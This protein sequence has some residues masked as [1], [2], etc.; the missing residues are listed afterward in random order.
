MGDA[1]E[2]I[3]YAAADAIDAAL[4]REQRLLE[5]LRQYGC[6]VHNGT[7]KLCASSIHSKNPCDCGLAAALSG[8]RP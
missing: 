3:G 7:G 8:D 1:G 5:L 6:H 4:A 2:Q